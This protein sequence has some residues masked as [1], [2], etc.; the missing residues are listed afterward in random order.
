MSFL[1]SLLFFTGLLFAE[2][3]IVV[4]EVWVRAVP[5]VASMSAAFLKIRN[6]GDEEDVLVGVVSSASEAAEVH[7]TTVEGGMM[8]M[9]RLDRVPIPP[10]VR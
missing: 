4:E 10:G 8:R 3:R 2:P 9:R 1:L 5:P 6:T 7:A